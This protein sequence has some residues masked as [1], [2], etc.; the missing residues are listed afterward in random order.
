MKSGKQFH[1]QNKHQK[2]KN[3]LNQGG[4]RKLQNLEERN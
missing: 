2:K 3:K 4:E 1:S